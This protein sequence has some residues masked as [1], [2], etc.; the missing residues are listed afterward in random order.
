MKVLSH[1]SS[2]MH[3]SI[4][5]EKAPEYSYTQKDKIDMSDHECIGQSSG[6]NDISS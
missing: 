4:S 2:K 3:P 5:E 1:T 6:E